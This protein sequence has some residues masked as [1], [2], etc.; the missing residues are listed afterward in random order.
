MSSKHS[1]CLNIRMPYVVFR[2]AHHSK[3]EC[4]ISNDSIFKC[5]LSFVDRLDIECRLLSCRDAQYSNIECC[6][7]SGPI[8]ECRI[9]YVRLFNIR[10]SNVCQQGLFEG[11]VLDIE[12]LNIRMLNVYR[13]TLISKV[14]CRINQH[15]CLILF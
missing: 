8:F 4:H 12:R 3:V 11:R 7:S 13:M 2:A 14:D 1:L 9:S 15:G 6:M 5:L 10:M